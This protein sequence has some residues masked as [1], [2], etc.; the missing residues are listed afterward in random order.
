M[1]DDDDNRNK[2]L[3]TTMM[4]ICGALFLRRIGG[5]I[6]VM[7]I[8]NHLTLIVIVKNNLKSITIDIIQYVHGSQYKE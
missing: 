8:C 6:F 2:D 4:R 3:T 7:T 5:D 1:R